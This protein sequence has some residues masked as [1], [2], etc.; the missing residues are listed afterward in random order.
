MLWE[1][2]SVRE[3]LRKGVKKALFLLKKRKGPRPCTGHDKVGGRR[4]RKKKGSN[5]S[6]RAG[7]L[8]GKILISLRRSGAVKGGR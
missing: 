3:Q 4:D 7:E 6:S 5:P 1:K 2:G 8:L